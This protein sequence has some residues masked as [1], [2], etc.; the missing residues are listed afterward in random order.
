MNVADMMSSQ[1]LDDY[2]DESNPYASLI[3]DGHSAEA[4]RLVHEVRE[5]H[6]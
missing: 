1:N 3:F 6:H 2:E 5:C 4:V